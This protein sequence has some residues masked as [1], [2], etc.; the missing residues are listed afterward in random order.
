MCARAQPGECLPSAEFSRGVI[1][2]P[3]RG[4]N[5]SDHVLYETAKIFHIIHLK[6]VNT[7]AE[8]AESDWRVRLPCASCRSDL[9]VGV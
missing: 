2:Q 4:L 1:A 6:R 9:Q 8:K 3:K 7:A 5:P